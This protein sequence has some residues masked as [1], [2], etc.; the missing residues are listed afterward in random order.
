MSVRTITREDAA[1]I[2]GLSARHMLRLHSEPDPPPWLG[3]GYH[4]EQFGKWLRRRW[5]R[6]AG[7]TD[8]GQVYDYETE[9]ARLT[10]AQ[11]DKTELEARELRGE[12][13]MAEHVIE[14]WSRMLGA[15]RAR[16]LSLPSKVGPRARAAA[17]DEEAAR[18]IEAEVLEAL[19]E[20]SGDGLPERTR[21]RRAGMQGGAPA[22][23]AVDGEPVGRR[24]S[25]SKPGKRR[26]AGSLAD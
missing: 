6:E 18:V 8:S 3:N 22:A 5:M 23:A 2:V 9:R 15:V 12:M 13:V 4:C 1:A 7:V 20:L 10:K 17:G 25:A 11:A 14:S 19:E 21:S 16:L 24:V 26:R